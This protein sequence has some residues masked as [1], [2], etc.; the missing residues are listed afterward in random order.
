MKGF[1]GLITIL[2]NH[3]QK[4]LDGN[5]ITKIEIV[6]GLTGEWWDMFWW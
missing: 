4:G 2:E 6:K 3:N 1:K 5:N